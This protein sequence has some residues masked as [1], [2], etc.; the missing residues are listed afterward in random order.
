MFFQEKHNTKQTIKK[1]AKKTRKKKTCAE[2]YNLIDGS[3]KER[4]KER[5]L[6]LEIPSYL[7]SI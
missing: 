7:E 5:K 1:K 3:L 6:R 2:S 4:K